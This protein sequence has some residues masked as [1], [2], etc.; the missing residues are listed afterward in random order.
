MDES[1]SNALLKWVHERE[2]IRLKR[3]AGLPPPWTNDPILKQFRFCNVRREH[4]QVTRF[5]NSVIRIPYDNDEHRKYL[6]LL[7]SISRWFNL[8]DTLLFLIRNEFFP[9]ANVTWIPNFK[10][11]ADALLERS[12][13]GHKIFNGAY[14]IPNA[15]VKEDKIRFVLEHVM[16]ELW[17]NRSRIHIATKGIENQLKSVHEEFTNMFAWGPFMAYQ[18]VID[19]RHTRLL[20][21]ATDATTFIACGPGTIRGFKR[22]FG[23]FHQRN[24]AS[25]VMEVQD[26]INDFLDIQLEASDIANC[27]CELDKY[28]RGGSK[29]VYRYSDEGTPQRK[30]VNPLDARRRGVFSAT[31]GRPRH[32]GYV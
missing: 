1:A 29:S 22:L 13:Q 31:R 12:Q 17:T 3:E 19:L 28:M 6:P 5:I 9:M 32:R 20:S 25:M 26:L 4:D 21:H 7:L 15:G 2:C 30:Y 23:Y 24:I 8:P 18:V 16:K 10:G 14:I 27:M 11:M